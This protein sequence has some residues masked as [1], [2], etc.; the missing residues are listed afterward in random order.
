PS[1][2]RRLRHGLGDWR[3]LARLAG[4]VATPAPGAG[5]GRDA[6]KS[7]PPEFRGLRPGP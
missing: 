6:L 2:R 1:L 3:R 5:G 7:D 4:G